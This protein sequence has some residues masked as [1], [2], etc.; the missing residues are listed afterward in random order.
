M[1][2]SFFVRHD[3]L[4]LAVVVFAATILVGGYQVWT[5]RQ[6]THTSTRITRT[7]STCAQVDRLYSVIVALEVRASFAPARIDAMREQRRARLAVQGCA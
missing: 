5:G 1:N 3:R 6:Q 2:R 7:T 4:V